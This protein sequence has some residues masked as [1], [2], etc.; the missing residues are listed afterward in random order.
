MNPS[1]Y[2]TGLKMRRGRC[3]SLLT[4]ADLMVGDRLVYHASW[5]QAR[6]KYSRSLNVPCGLNTRGVD[7]WRACV[8]SNLQLLMYILSVLG[9]KE[10]RIC[11]MGRLG[12]WLVMAIRVLVVAGAVGGGVG[13]SM[14]SKKKKKKKKKKNKKKKNKKKKKRE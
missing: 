7:E 11:G 6:E 2:S 9:P 13:G 5:F 4:P 12:S 3:T 1:H 14:A 10:R 8:I